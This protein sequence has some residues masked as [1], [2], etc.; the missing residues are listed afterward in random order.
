MLPSISSDH[1]EDISNL[2]L[3]GSSPAPLSPLT[4]TPQSQPQTLGHAEKSQ[5]HQH[6]YQHQPLVQHP[7]PVKPKVKTG[8]F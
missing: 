6:Q 4:H 5:Q 2:Q 7:D 3:K 1:T 8:E